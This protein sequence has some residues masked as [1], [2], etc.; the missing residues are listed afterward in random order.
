MVSKKGTRKLEFEGNIFYWFVRRNAEGYK[1]IH[2]LS[3]D[4]KVH[5]EFTPIDSEAII[6]PAFIRERLKNYFASH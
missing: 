6:E 3:E 5:L 1:R 4:K 2:I